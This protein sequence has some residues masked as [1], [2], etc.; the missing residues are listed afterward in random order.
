MPTL[1]VELSS[2]ITTII[3]IARADRR[4][5]RN[6]IRSDPRQQLHHSTTTA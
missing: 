4:R 3:A 5:I 1:R 2:D 6:A